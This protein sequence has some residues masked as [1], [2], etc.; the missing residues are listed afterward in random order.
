MFKMSSGIKSW[1][2]KYCIAVLLCFLINIGS[3]CTSQP[4]VVHE[5]FIYTFQ[6]ELF[7][8]CFSI[9]S[10]RFSANKDYIICL[11]AV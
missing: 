6:I 5:I 3:I 4:H 11:F 2:I 7:Q 1:M 10:D 9:V 8:F